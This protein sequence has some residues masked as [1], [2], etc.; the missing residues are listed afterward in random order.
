MIMKLIPAILAALLSAFAYGQESIGLHEP[1]RL[2]SPENPA[3]LA[4]Y[5]TIM[6]GVS[7]DEGKFTLRAVT[8]LHEEQKVLNNTTP[9]LWRAGCVPTAGTMVLLHW[10][11]KGFNKVFGSLRNNRDLSLSQGWLNTQ[12]IGSEE[13]YRDYFYP[14]DLA[15]NLLPDRSGNQV[16]S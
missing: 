8:E 1:V 4:D 10:E 11:S 3:F 13:H 15:P 9:L 6:T 2:N 12:L 14:T 7:P 16:I 5:T